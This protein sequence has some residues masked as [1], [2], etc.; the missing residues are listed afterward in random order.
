MSTC[1]TCKFWEKDKYGAPGGTCQAATPLD[2]FADDVPENGLG[3][4]GI[5]NGS[6]PDS[7]PEIYTG[8][9]F[10]CVLHQTKELSDAR[11]DR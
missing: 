10:G 4:S 11:T 3:T 9:K 1:D 2:S 6:Y 7:Y 8:P 5:S